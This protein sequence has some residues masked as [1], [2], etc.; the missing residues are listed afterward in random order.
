MKFSQLAVRLA[1]PQ[2]VPRTAR[3]RGVASVLG[4]IQDG[5]AAVT[6]EELSRED[7]G[8]DIRRVDLGRNMRDC[9]NAGAAHLAHLE[10]LT[11]DVA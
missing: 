2:A 5:R 6:L 1:V 4:E 10:K 8:E 9:H 11:I 3:R 7:L